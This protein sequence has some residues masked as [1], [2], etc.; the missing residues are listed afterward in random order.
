[1]GQKALHKQCTINSMPTS[2][3]LQYVCMSK[4]KVT[5]NSS[6]L[7]DG[8][9]WY[10][11]RPLAIPSN[12]GDAEVGLAS[13]FIISC[14][15]RDVKE[16]STD[17]VNCFCFKSACTHS[18]GLGTCWKRDQPP[19]PSSSGRLKTHNCIDVKAS[20]YNL[21]SSMP[22]GCGVKGKMVQTLT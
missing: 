2:N 19:L 5:A 20:K 6:A 13:S 18:K 11:V 22:M 8:G 17:N 14:N 1:M 4:A 10:V 12:D 7:A 16:L 3:N 9:K 15:T 21:A